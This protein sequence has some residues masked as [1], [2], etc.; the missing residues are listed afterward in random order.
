ML[1]DSYLQEPIKQEID[2]KP[3]QNNAIDGLQLECGHFEIPL[4][5][6][7]LSVGKGRLAVSRFKAT[8]KPKGVL[9]VHAGK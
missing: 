9:F 1:T 5:W 3:C 4:D 6:H 7:D 2:W 8:K